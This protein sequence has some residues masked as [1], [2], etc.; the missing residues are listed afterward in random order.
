M[1]NKKSRAKNIIAE[2]IKLEDK[3]NNKL[4][5]NFLVGL[6]YNDGDLAKLSEGTS[7]FLGEGYISF[8]EGESEN[9]N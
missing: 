8:K 7:D 3:N 6:M 1:N 4:K 2:V 9:E 5:R